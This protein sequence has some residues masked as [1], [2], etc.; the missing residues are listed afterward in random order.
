[1]TCKSGWCSI[2]QLRPICLCTS[3]PK[4]SQIMGTTRFSSVTHTAVHPKANCLYA[5]SQYTWGCDYPS[6]VRARRRS[7]PATTGMG[8]CPRACTA[9]ERD[10]EQ[11]E[12]EGN[13]RTRRGSGLGRQGDRGE[14]ENGC[15][16]KIVR[17]AYCGK[18]SG[19]RIGAPPTGSAHFGFSYVF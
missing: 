16:G 13:D 2:E 17:T 8:R 11:W 6:V 7:L 10:R 19:I 15:A 3:V 1:M 9:V 12:R 4:F 14:R 18:K 5:M